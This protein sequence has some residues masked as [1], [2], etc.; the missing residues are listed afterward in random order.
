M[1]KMTPS[2]NENVFPKIKIIFPNFLGNII[3]LSK[4]IKSSALAS[5][6]YKPMFLRLF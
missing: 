3:L 1:N 6:L 2:D 4:E 5:D